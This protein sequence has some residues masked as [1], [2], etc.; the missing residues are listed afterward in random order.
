MP[1]RLHKL[2]AAAGLGSRREI[3]D[4][5]RAGRVTVNGTPASIGQ[6]IELRDRVAIDK[7]PFRFKLESKTGK[8]RAP[9]VLIYNKP[10]GEIVSRDDPEGRPSVFTQLPRLR[11]AKWIAVGRL[12]INS[13]GLLLFTTSG[14][15]ANRL[16]HPRYEIERE[17]AV[18]VMGVLTKVQSQ[19]LLQGIEMEDGL[20]KFE[21]I[22]DRGGE[23][24]NHWYHVVL[25]EGR[26]RE[27]RRIF[28][29]VGLMVSRLIRVRYGPVGLPPRVKRGQSLDLEPA[30]VQALLGSV[31][32]LG[33]QDEK[34]SGDRRPERPVKT[35]R[36]STRPVR[37]EKPK[38]GT[39]ASAKR[40]ER[41]E[42]SGR[43]RGG[44][45]KPSRSSRSSRPAAGKR[46]ERPVAA[47]RETGSVDKP[48]K[49]TRSPRAS[50]A[51]PTGAGQARGEKP[52]APK[53][54]PR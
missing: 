5:I 26:K 15:L 24:S 13:G 3:E 17:Y 29:A 10:E 20:G 6:S 38:R 27:V 9:R 44:E 34:S 8:L 49:P 42:L 7:K 50:I 46:S 30:Q 19:Q 35:G 14:D 45:D 54:K 37:T 23:G 40:F 16:M 2:L 33:D 39:H 48:S 11:G 25:K 47:K 28:Q 32:L 36:E 4:W 12:D 31:G 1:E 51:R 52:S 53:R 41:S 18:R 43:E 21:L 22:E